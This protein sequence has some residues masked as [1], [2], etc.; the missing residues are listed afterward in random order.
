MPPYWRGK[1]D[2]TQGDELAALCGSYSEWRYYWYKSYPNDLHC[3]F[4]DGCGGT[5]SPR[6]RDRY[7]SHKV[8]ESSNRRKAEKIRKEI[9]DRQLW[10]DRHD[11]YEKL[12]CSVDID[13]GDDDGRA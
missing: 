13:D 1:V 2:K 3:E 8:L 10:L 7:T 4:R 12:Y 11:A 5:R 9:V 6:D